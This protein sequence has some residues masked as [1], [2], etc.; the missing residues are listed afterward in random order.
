MNAVLKRAAQWAIPQGLI[1]R[2]LRGGPVALTFDDGPHPQV[3]PQVLALLD[4]FGVRATF[5]V[6]GRQA[7]RHP[8]LLAEIHQAGHEIANHSYSHRHARQVRGMEAFREELQ[9]TNQSIRNVTGRTPRWYRPPY[10]ELKPGMLWACW[11]A[12]MRI[13]LWSYDAVDYSASPVTPASMAETVAPG[14]IVL[15]HD[16]DPTC[17]RLLA[18][19]VPSLLERGMR[20]GLLP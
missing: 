4:R 13:V 14:D 18:S 5:F 3:T 12:S 10:G 1:L 8:E 9:R 20:F 11:R 19:A 6:V 17:L 7:E 16:D 2:H 15:L